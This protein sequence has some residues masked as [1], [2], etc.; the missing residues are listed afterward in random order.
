MKEYESYPATVSSHRWSRRSFSIGRK[1]IRRLSGTLVWICS[2][3]TPSPVSGE[4]EEESGARGRCRPAASPVS[5]MSF[6]ATQKVIATVLPSPLPR[7]QRCSPILPWLD[8]DYTSPIPSRHDSGYAPPVLNV[9]AVAL[10]H[11]LRYTAASREVATIV[12]VHCGTDS[13]AFLILKALILGL[14]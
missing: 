11:A 9:T 4:A 1:G 8:G 10:L 2:Q 3:G 6:S 5:L 13:G 14:L 7:Q 12:P